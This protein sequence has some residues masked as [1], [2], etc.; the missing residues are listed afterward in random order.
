MNVDWIS[1]KNVCKVC[2][3]D[4]A[5]AETCSTKAQGCF[6]RI[7]VT[8]LGSSQKFLVIFNEV[9]SKKLTASL[10]KCAVALLI[11][12]GSSYKPIVV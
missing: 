1:C 8:F 6:C 12:I 10:T 7:C 9:C 11:L 2:E 3:V 4:F 5:K